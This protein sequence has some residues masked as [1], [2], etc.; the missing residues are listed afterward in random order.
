MIGGIN[1][2]SRFALLA[3]MGV[4]AGG[5]SS[6]SAADLGGNCC[7]DLEERI[8]ELEATTARK[9]NRKVSLTVSGWVNQAVLY[10]DDGRERNIYQYD[11]AAPSR[12]RFSGEAKINAAMKAGYL[13]EIGAYAV[14]PD[15]VNRDNDENTAA[16]IATA[17]TPFQVR[18]SAWWISHN[19]LGKVWLGQTSEST[20]SITEIN[21]SNTG[22]FAGP[23]VSYLGLQGF[24][25]R[26][27]GSVAA[28]GF[29]ATVLTFFGNDSLQNVGEGQR[30]NIVKYETPTIMGF[31]GS[32][33]FGEDDMWS[34][35]LRYAG[36]FSG[37]KLAAGIGYRE[38]TDTNSTGALATTAATVFGCFGGTGAL[39][40]A[41]TGDTKCK[42]VGLSAS[43]M[44]VAT[45][46]FVTGAYGW[47]KDDFRKNAFGTDA[48]DTDTMFWV[49]GGIEQNWLGFGKTTIFGEYL[50]DDM[51]HQISTAATAFAEARGTM[52]GVGLNQA[53]DAAAMDLYFAYRQYS[54]D[55]WTQTAT[56]G[57]NL[58]GA[59]IQDINTFLAGG[60][61]KF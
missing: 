3:A 16:T 15:Q 14:R 55:G 59:E 32:A 45:G 57:K 53:I 60:I 49:Q 29:G 22:H 12:F 31:I 23:A 17:G 36:E 21:L 39:A 42:Q 44:H 20:D 34:V 11:G 41:A 37:F 56:G 8:A 38:N 9:G 27:S 33:S 25:P 6:A 24:T 1:K 61:I 54:F 35:A 40:I 13:L 48:K 51:G 18:H 28:N 7:A 43:V 5:V 2:I 50:Q 19:D 47:R 26:A 30:F 46:L 58:K 4:L 52:W 10:W